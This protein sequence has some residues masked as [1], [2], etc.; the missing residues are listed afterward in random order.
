MSLSQI[1]FTTCIGGL[2]RLRASGKSGITRSPGFL[3]A[4]VDESGTSPAQAFLDADTLALIRTA[5]STAYRA[6]GH[7]YERAP[8]TLP[9]QPAGVRSHAVNQHGLQLRAA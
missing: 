3:K 8:A 5:Y 2:G 4:T 7:L 6:C 9:L 1:D